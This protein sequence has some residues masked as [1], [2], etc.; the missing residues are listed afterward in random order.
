[1]DIIALKI[2]ACICVSVV[3]G[4]A[5]WKDEFFS[6]GMMLIIGLYVIFS[7]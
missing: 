7:M 5:A 1:M 4:I 3:A 2:V 6:A